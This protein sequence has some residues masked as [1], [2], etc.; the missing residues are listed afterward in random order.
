MMG[1]CSRKHDTKSDNISSVIYLERNNLEIYSKTIK[2]NKI[3]IGSGFLSDSKIFKTQKQV[4]ENFIKTEINNILYVGSECKQDEKL[5]SSGMHPF[6][7]AVHTAYSKHLSLNISP[8][9]I[10]YLIASAASI[11]INKNSEQLRSTFVNHKGKEK[12]SISVGTIIDWNKVIS[13]F[14]DKI[15]LKTN[16]N[17][18][19]KFQAD[20]TTTNEYSKIVSQIVLMESMKSYFEYSLFTMCGIPEIRLSGTKQD[21]LKVKS[22]AESLLQLLPGLH[23]VW[24]TSLNEILDNFINV[25]EDKIDSEFWNQFYKFKGGSGGEFISGWIIAL[26]PY[27]KNNEKNEYIF[28]EKNWN[29]IR[30]DIKTD[31]FDYHMNHAPFILKKEFEDEKKNVVR[32]WIYWNKI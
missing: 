21:W 6:V 11:H 15:A 27:L 30:H 26:F 12:I 8:D 1:S 16:N 4:I 13:H 5:I 17:I 28:G 25:Y 2:T 31:S 14:T 7:N 29:V 19:D 3:I 18:A 9:M 10:W 23:Q 22:K 32:W 24:L 20:F